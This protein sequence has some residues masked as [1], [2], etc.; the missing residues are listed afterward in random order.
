MA[1]QA[2]LPLKT[3]LGFGIGDLGGNLFFTIM[4]FY[5]LIYLTDTVHLAAGLAGTAIM[6]GKIWDAVT[7][8]A[9]GYWSDHTR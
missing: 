9:V 1:T 7:D 5:L 4:G 2:R 6:I 8:P 3:R